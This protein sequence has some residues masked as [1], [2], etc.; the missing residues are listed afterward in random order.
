LICLTCN[1]GFPLKRVPLH[2]S[3]EH[4]ISKTIYDPILQSFIRETTLT[5]DWKD[6]PLPPDNIL[7]IEELLIKSGF[8]CTGCGHRTTSYE[9]AKDHFKCA[10]EVRQVQLQCWNRTSASKNPTASVK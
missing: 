10:G 4:H 9:I 1:K 5:T 8:F 6:L 7:P 2:L 3:R